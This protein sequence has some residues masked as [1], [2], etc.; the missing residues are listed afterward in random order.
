MRRVLLA[1]ALAAVSAA[2]LAGGDAQAGKANAA[3]CLACH[4]NHLLA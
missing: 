3:A 2:A 1:A 4:G